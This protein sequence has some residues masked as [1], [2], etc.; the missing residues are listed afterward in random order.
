[1]K[2]HFIWR[3]IFP[4]VLL[5]S[6]ISPAKDTKLKP[7][8]VVARH[9]ASIGAPEA[10]S[11]VRSRIMSGKGQTISRMPTS[12]QS[13][14]TATVQSEGRKFAFKWLFSA[15]DYPSEQ[16]LF[17]GNKVNVAQIRPGQKSHYSAFIYQHD[18]LLK[19]GLLGGTMTT[20][21]ALLDVAGRQPKLEYS[22]I[23]KFDG[24]DLHEIKYRM[25]K[26]DSG[27]Q[28]YLY[29][30]PETFRHV[31]SRYR[32]IQPAA[33]GATPDAS[34][35]QRDTIYTIEEMFG[36]FKTVDSVT[37]PHGYKSIYTVEGQVNTV[38]QQW[39]IVIESVA[40]NQPLGPNAFIVQ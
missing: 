36:D 25:K 1:M 16:L 19:E 24:K 5:F 20:A 21:W 12:G 32:M 31:G 6:L 8:E 33:M 9:L 22:G 34:S 10:L 40:H 26:G 15:L 11:G 23:K 7:E 35:G 29:F 2:I 17:D 4:A 27:I 18:S 39:V 30:E 37:I 38:M 14:G 28:V 3:Q 13:S